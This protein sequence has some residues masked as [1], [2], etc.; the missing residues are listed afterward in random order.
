[1]QTRKRSGRPPRVGGPG[2]RERFISAVSPFT[3]LP[4]VPG[5]LR[6][7]ARS[8]VAREMYLTWRSGVSHAVLAK[9]CGVSATTVSNLVHEATAREAKSKAHWTGGQS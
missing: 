3:S 2:A 1:M 6:D 4:W 5:E 8:V 7:T 9:W